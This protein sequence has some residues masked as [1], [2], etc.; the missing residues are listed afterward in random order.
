MELPPIVMN[1]VW[2]LFDYNYL[3]DPIPSLFPL[4]FEQLKQRNGFVLYSTNIS[5]HPSDPA[6]LEINGLADRA[7]VFVDSVFTKNTSILV[8]KM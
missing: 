5:I 8:P 7:Q 6:V 4:T 3:E 2:S 1:P